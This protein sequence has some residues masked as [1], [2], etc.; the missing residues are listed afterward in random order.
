MNTARFN[1]VASK[2]APRCKVVDVDWR[3]NGQTITFDCGHKTEWVAHFDV[4]P[5]RD[6]GTCRECGRLAAKKLPE[7]SS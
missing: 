7:F 1:F 2:I 6:Y 4:K 5:H 3:T